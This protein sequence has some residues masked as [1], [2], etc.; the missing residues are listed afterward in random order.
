MCISSRSSEAGRGGGQPIKRVAGFGS[1]QVMADRA[2]PADARGDVGHF[3]VHAAFA[4]LF[5]AAEFIDVHIRLFDFTGIIQVDGD[6]GM[7][8]DPGYWFDRDFLCCHNVPLI[9]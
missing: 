5:K 8:F 1:R 9:S 2:N 6:L 3:E 4:E 7:S